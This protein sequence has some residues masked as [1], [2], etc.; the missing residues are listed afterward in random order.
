M[1]IDDNR[2]SLTCTGSKYTGSI[3][4]R[5][6]GKNQRPPATGGSTMAYAA[7][8][9]AGAVQARARVRGTH[10]RGVVRGA[11]ARESQDL[12]RPARG[13]HSCATLS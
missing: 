3:Q 6:C 10:D 4:E 5:L 12:W 13:P 7:S 9:S 11:C 2:W 8:I 1:S